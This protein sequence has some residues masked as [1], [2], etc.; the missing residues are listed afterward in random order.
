MKKTCT[1]LGG[2]CESEFSSN[3][4]DAIAALSHE[5]GMEMSYTKDATYPA[6][7]EE[8]GKRRK[9]TKKCKNGW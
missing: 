9:Y 4:F 7:I 3:T 2:A 8:M 1:D 6:D 5:H